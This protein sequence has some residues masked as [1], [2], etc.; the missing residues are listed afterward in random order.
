[1]SISALLPNVAQTAPVL[2]PAAQPASRPSAAGADPVP[3]TVVFS[4]AP[5]RL[6]ADLASAGLRQLATLL[7]AL[8]QA[9]GL[10]DP[11]PLGHLAK[12]AGAAARQVEEG[13]AALLAEGPDRVAASLNGEQR[14]RAA[15]PD[16]ATQLLR[17]LARQIGSA[18]PQATEARASE[19]L[20][21]IARQIGDSVASLPDRASSPPA[22][23]SRSESNEPQPRRDPLARLGGEPVLLPER[24]LSQ[25]TVP[26]RPESPEQ[27]RNPLAPQ[28]NGVPP[29]PAD[30]RW[31][32]AP[33]P[34]PR[35]IG[36]AFEL[37]DA[38]PAAP[39]DAADRWLDEA[40]HLL[41]RAGDVLDQAGEQLRPLIAE[42]PI[43]SPQIGWALSQIV[44][45]QVQLSSAVARLGTRSKP[46]SGGGAA[47]AWSLPSMSI[48]LERLSHA[49][50]L[51]GIMLVLFAVW[52]AEGVWTL[53][54]GVAGLVTTAFWVFRISQAARGVTLDA[55]R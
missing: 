47:A 17:T 37:P 52:L 42:T 24:P 26:S 54:A 44:A 55:R 9:V 21:T 5:L 11:V 23:A 51:A 15:A 43:P 49:A 19:A 1:M 6:L 39:A 32:D 34:L 25:P 48:P 2:D 27:P 40:Q 38:R 20:R 7:P 45:A 3:D 33:T 12:A 53:A 18:P 4:S 13:H 10:P 31:N 8:E 50:G 14:A 46:V 29:Q 28:P 16:Q 41:H 35:P 30:S 36:S 22:T